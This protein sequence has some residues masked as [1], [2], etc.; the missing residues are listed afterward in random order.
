MFRWNGR[1]VHLSLPMGMDI[2]KNA[3]FQALNPL[4]FS[5]LH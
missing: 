4:L 3:M 1:N 2:S 5:I